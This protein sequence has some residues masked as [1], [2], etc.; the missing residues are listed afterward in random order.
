MSARISTGIITSWNRG[1]EQL[2]GYTAGEAVGRSIT[3]LIPPDRLSEEDMVLARI[4]PGER[5]DHFDTRRRRKDGTLVDVS[6]TVSPI[7]DATGAIVGAS[8]IARDISERIRIDAELQTLQ[9]RLMALAVASASILGSPN[10]ETVL[11]AT[12]DLARDVFS[13]DGYGLWRIDA[14]GVWRMARSFGISDEFA[15]RIV[16][17]S[18]GR[19]EIP[20]VP[21]TEP[22][23]C[24]DVG[25]APMLAE[26]RDAYTREGI[27]SMIVFPLLI[28]GERSATMVF[29]SRQP[30]R[31]S[32]RGR[33]CRYG[34]GQSCGRVTDHRGA[35]RRT[36]AGPRGRR[37]RAA[38][39][40]VSCRGR[41]GPQCLARLPG[42]VDARSRNWRC[43]RLPTGARSTSSGERGALHR[44]AVAHVDPEKVEL[45]RAL[46]ERY[47][48]DPNASGGVHEVIRTGRPAFMSRIPAGLIAAASR[49]ETKNV[50]A[51][52]KNCT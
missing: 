30:A 35:V 5:V 22:L 51:S 13:S 39:G 24:E 6:V 44:L 29:Y 49:R 43:P 50:D 42:D 47:P 14:G 40:H 37:P 11:S 20:R 1:A 25:T 28:R 46:Q 2:F 52:S 32:R 21:F 16:T 17:G 31:I 34:P 41:H 26:M 45:A 4:R 15:A 3:I 38:A 36:T 9:H 27:A 48:A 8:K 18:A 7:R 33:S 10:V 19:T 23:I 12:L